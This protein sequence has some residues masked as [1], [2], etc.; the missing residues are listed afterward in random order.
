MNPIKITYSTLVLPTGVFQLQFD[1]NAIADIEEISGMNICSP[2]GN[3]VLSGVFGGGSVSPSKLRLLFYGSLRAYHKGISLEGAG[4]MIESSSIPLII[5][6][7]TESLRIAYPPADAA[8]AET[9]G[10][11]ANPS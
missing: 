11:S 5:A 10:P 2:E 6:A 4:A 1:W 7:L 8:N 3:Q 9:S